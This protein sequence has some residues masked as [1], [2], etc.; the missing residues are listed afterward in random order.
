M[1]LLSR[2]NPDNEQERIKETKRLRR[3]QRVVS[4]VISL[5]AEQRGMGHRFKS[6]RLGSFVFFVP[7]FSLEW[8]RLGFFSSLLLTLTCGY[9]VLNAD[10]AAWAA[11]VTKA[12]G[13]TVYW[14]AWGGDPRINAYIQW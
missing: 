8:F 13:Q 6:S 7:I 9:S 3:L 5:S 12:R 10:D 2:H 11:I 14:N 4:L 1:R